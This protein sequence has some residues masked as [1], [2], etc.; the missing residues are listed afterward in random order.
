MKKIT[1][2]LLSFAALLCCQ[3]S[4]AQNI[5]EK[6]TKAHKYCESTLPYEDGVL[7]A[8]FGT[9]QL[10]PLNNEGKGYISVINRK[11]GKEKTLIKANGSLN[12]PKGM[13]TYGNHLLVADVNK[14]MVFDL[15]KPSK[16]PHTINF[17]SEDAF[18]NDIVVLEDRALV[19]VTNTGNIYAIDLKNINNSSFDKVQ[20]QLITNLPGANGL[21]LNGDN[22]YAA[23]YNPTGVPNDDNVL[24]VAS[25]KTETPRFEKLVENLT[26]GQYDGIVV[27]KDGETVYFTSWTGG[28]DQ[29]GSL[30][31]LE[32]NEP[33]AEP[34]RMELE[35]K[36]IGPAAISIDEDGNLWLPDLATSSVYKIKLK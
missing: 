6:Y 29:T 14:V 26:P 20:P 11:N 34:K 35:E 30:Y 1:F 28:P 3:E 19:S 7:V 27:T 33:N 25:I 4:Q 23:S 17:P 13:A 22:I 2:S 31:S 16:T 10:D 5:V 36:L 24:Y 8:S 15:D 32:L 12:G 21:A 18:V 9:D